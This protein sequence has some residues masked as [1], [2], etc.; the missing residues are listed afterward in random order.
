VNRERA[1]LSKEEHAKRDT[2]AE[3]MS[4]HKLALYESR[5]GIICTVDKK[6]VVKTKKAGAYPS[7]DEINEFLRFPR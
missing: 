1:A 3:V 5:D 6:S 2:L 7:E 4:E